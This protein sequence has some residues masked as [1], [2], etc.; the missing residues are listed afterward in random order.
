M[1]GLLLALAD[2]AKLLAGLHSGTVI[3]QAD[4]VLDLIAKAFD[5]VSG[6]IARRPGGLGTNTN[7]GRWATL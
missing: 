4:Q 1:S 3:C 5:I 6:V 7:R 2:H